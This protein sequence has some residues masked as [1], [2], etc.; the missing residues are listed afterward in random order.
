MPIKRK[1][2][3]RWSTHIKQLS[4]KRTQ[5]MTGNQGSGSGQE[6]KYWGV[7]AVNVVRTL[8]VMIRSKDME[9]KIVSTVLKSKH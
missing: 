6:H 7:K 8:S 5:R 2:K 4:T 3:Q 1:F 9:K